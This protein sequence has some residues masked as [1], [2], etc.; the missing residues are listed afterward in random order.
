[1]QPEAMLQPPCPGGGGPCLDLDVCSPSPSL[2][3]GAI[4]G[5]AVPTLGSLGATDLVVDETKL[6]GY[7]G[8]PSPNVSWR[9]VE[10]SVEQACL[11]VV[12]TDRLLREAVA[13]IIC[14]VLHPIWVSLKKK[15][16]T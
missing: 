15:R 9:Q 16:L 12:I 4:P 7:P 3:R 1:M 8:A 13:M 14:N 11:R 6:P 10:G 2:P 5:D